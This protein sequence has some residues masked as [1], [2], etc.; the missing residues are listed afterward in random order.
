MDQKRRRSP[1]VKVRSTALVALGALAMGAAGAPP[2]AAHNNPKN[3]V[4]AIVSVEPRVPGLQVSV[5][6]RSGYVTITNRT[7][8]TVLVFGD[9]H[10][11]YLMLTGSGAWLNLRSPTRF[12]NQG[13]APARASEPVSA[14]ASPHWQEVA[15]GSTYRF[16]D[17]RIHWTGK[18]MPTVVSQDPNKPH[19]IKA[20]AIDL[21]VGGTP[22]TIRGTL[23]WQPSGGL[24]YVAFAA[25][26]CCVLICFCV[27][28]VL[29][30]RRS[31]GEPD[32]QRLGP[33]PGADLP[34]AFAVRPPLASPAERRRP[35]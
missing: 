2:A 24:A 6:S 13:T 32:P 20:W 9:E 29:D 16:H 8:R 33:L 11:P 21:L 14:S 7:G 22:V 3:Y 10:E 17:A 12:T 18:G 15:H 25:I 19:L 23:R 26:G 35:S 34:A 30:H 4:T 5:T 31:R 27:A 1:W 28:I